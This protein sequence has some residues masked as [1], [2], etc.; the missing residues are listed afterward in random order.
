MVEPL[1]IDDHPSESPLLAAKNYDVCL[2]LLAWFAL[3]WLLRLIHLFTTYKE[4]RRYAA[5]SSCRFDDVPFH[6]LVVPLDVD[7]RRR[8]LAYLRTRVLPAP[9]AAAPAYTSPVLLHSAKLTGPRGSA[10]LELILE[11]AH[12]AALQVYWGGTISSDPS[13]YADSLVPLNKLSRRDRPSAE[14]P[15]YS[16]PSSSRVG[17]ECGSGGGSDRGSSSS[18]SSAT[19]R[20]LVGSVRQRLSMSARTQPVVRELSAIELS[21]PSPLSQRRCDGGGGGSSS[22][23]FTTSGAA[24]HHSSQPTLGQPSYAKA[25]EPSHALQPRSYSRCSPPIRIAGG[26][27]KTTITL[28]PEQTAARNDEIFGD[29]GATLP[30][31][32]GS[33]AVLLFS[34]ISSQVC[35]PCANPE[36]GGG[37]Q[38]PS[39]VINAAPRAAAH[40]VAISL[41]FEAVEGDTPA[42]TASGAPA[43]TDPLQAAGANSKGMKGVVGPHVL[44]TP[45]GP[46]KLAEI[47]GQEN[48]VDEP[49]VACLTDPREIIL[50]PCR[51]LCVCSQCFSH[52]TIDRCPVC[53]AAFS[54]YLRFEAPEGEGGDRD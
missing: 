25:I 40:A 5:S 37:T 29:T 49:C 52:L 21:T 26:P 43:A 6:N 36:G 14:A 19:A 4:A 39:A 46:M 38:L 41:T 42:T 9:T 22:S 35:Q 17:P 7:T 30:T 54:S 44:S 23:S 31:P 12:D 3:G 13:S 50:L 16:T 47:F 51:H 11:S 34:Q 2:I 45:E 10:S 20:T 8:F 1:L 27:E 28:T 48:W 32:E 18:F 24:G 33:T 15:S 53:R